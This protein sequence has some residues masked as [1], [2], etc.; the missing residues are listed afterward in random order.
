MNDWFTFDGN[1]AYV[2]AAWG[3][4]L[5]VVIWNIWAARVRLK[6]SLAAARREGVE[7][8]SPR[9]PRVTRL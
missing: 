8:E 2:W 3:I 6:R 5:V 1:G 9:R 4:T 7:T